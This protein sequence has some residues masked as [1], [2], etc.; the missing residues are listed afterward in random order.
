MTVP[1]QKALLLTRGDLPK[2]GIKLS[3]STLLRLE[4][5]GKFPKR[6]RLGGHSVAWLTTEIEAHV[7][8]LASARRVGQ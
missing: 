1:L 4:A 7:E 2:L 8:A 5:S 3:N 6:V